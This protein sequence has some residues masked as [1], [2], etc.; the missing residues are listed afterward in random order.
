MREKLKETTAGDAVLRL[1]KES[2]AY[3]GAVIV[4]KTVKVLEGTDAD[5][6]WRRMHDEVAKSNP[7]YLGFDGARNRFLHF[8]PDGYSSIDY[9]KR[10]RG[11]KLNAKSKLDETAPL[12]EAAVGSGF[13][14]AVTSVF[15]TN[16]LSPF[17][18]MRVRDALRGPTADDFIRAAA[19]FILAEPASHIERAIRRTSRCCG[20][21][22]IKSPTK[23]IFRSGFRKTPSISTYPSL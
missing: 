10:E 23:I 7:K 3:K 16:L 1:F 13:G 5:D 8:F 22:S 21:R 9:P 11:Y 14:E 15:E 2:G 17:E 20:P 6:V 12:E 19:R 18:K 4:G